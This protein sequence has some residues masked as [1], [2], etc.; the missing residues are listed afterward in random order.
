MTQ[1][2]N[3]SE[4]DDRLERYQRRRSRAQQSIQNDAPRQRRAPYKRE[5]VDYDH[6]L[7]EEELEDEW[8]EHNN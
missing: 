7:Q 1:E 3:N 4:R 6:Y 8:F 2:D 5:N